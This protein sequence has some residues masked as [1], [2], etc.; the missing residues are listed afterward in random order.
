MSRALLVMVNDDFR[1]R[2][3]NL[4]RSV[5]KDTR[6]EFKGPKRSI[7]QN[8]R[9]WSMLTEI[10]AQVV[11]Y[12]VKLAPEDWKLMMLDGLKRE[13]RIVPN[14][15]GTGFVNLGRSSSDLSKEEMTALIELIFA[16]GANHGVEFHE[17]EARDNG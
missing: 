3:I 14:I 2:A 13:V 17:P 9:M 5:P 15:D 7:P 16:F 4:V 6:I 12:G 10:S 11:W 1:R 8:D